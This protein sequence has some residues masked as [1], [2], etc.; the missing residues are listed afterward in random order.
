MLFF[1]LRMVEECYECGR[2][3]QQCLEEPAHFDGVTVGVALVIYSTQA[4]KL[5]IYMLVRHFMRAHQNNIYFFEEK[6]CIT[7][8][9][10]EK[11]PQAG[12][13]QSSI[14]EM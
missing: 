8:I 5:E 12:D 7:S 1:H 13:Q 6:S 9:T 10:G 11:K 14:F 4:I 2:K 3:G